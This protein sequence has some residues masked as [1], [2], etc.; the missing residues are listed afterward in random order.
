MSVYKNAMAAYKRAL[1]LRTLRSCGGNC[2][3]AAE[4]LGIHRNAMTRFIREGS[5]DLGKVRAEF[6]HS[7][8]VQEER[9][10][11]LTNKERAIYGCGIY[12]RRA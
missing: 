3:A 12:R 4:V 1:L 8:P 10:P 9:D 11:P 6:K 5:I 7:R 2:S